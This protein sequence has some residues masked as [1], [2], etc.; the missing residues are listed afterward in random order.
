ME[1]VELE[2]VDSRVTRL[3]CLFCKH[4][5]RFEDL[6]PLNQDGL[7]QAPCPHCATRGRSCGQRSSRQSVR[8]KSGR[9]IASLNASPIGDI[10]LIGQP[11]RSLKSELSLRRPTRG[12]FS[13][14]MT[15]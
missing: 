3:R 5:G 6:K 9:L 13:P 12:R 4:W 14:D 10:D 1:I 2:A 15:A 8:M 7:E 11:F